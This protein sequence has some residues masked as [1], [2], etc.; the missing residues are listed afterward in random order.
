MKNQCILILGLSLCFIFACNEDE[1][2]LNEAEL[3]VEAIEMVERGTFEGNLHF[4]NAQPEMINTRATAK[5]FLGDTGA[6]ILLKSELEGFIDTF[7]HVK[8]E[9]QASNVE[10]LSGTVSFT[11]D[12]ETLFQFKS[13]NHPSLSSSILP[14]RGCS[15]TFEGPLQD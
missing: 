1:G 3:C 6:A 8:F 15:F 7:Y 14:Y 2:C 4:C 9:C 5:V 11:K 12:A 13:G 10:C